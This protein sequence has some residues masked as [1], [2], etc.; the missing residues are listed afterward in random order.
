MPH[1]ADTNGNRVWQPCAWG[2]DYF[3]FLL[4]RTHSAFPGM[5]SLSGTFSALFWAEDISAMLLAIW[6]VGGGRPGKESHVMIK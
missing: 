3:V 6:L 5:L 2:K 4:A 1:T